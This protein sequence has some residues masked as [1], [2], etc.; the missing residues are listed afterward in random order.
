VGRDW[1]R[2]Q[3]I[4]IGIYFIIVIAPPKLSEM[5]RLRV[6]VV[7]WYHEPGRWGHHGRH[8]GRCELLPHVVHL[9]LW[10]ACRHW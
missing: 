1:A 4:D 8:R 7:L 9:L 2:G 3:K 10:L 5:G 6:G